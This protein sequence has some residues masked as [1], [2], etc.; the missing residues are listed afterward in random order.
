M[1]DEAC[2]RASAVRCLRPPASAPIRRTADVFV[3]AWPSPGTSGARRRVA[4]LR[5]DRR[6]LRFGRRLVDAFETLWF[7]ALDARAAAVEQRARLLQLVQ[8]GRYRAL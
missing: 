7:R 4:R 1:L 2:G 8:S 5:S 3:C 6:R